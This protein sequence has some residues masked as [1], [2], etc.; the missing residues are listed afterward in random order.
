MAGSFVGGRRVPPPPRLRW[1][2]LT[3]GIA[4]GVGG[5]VVEACGFVLVSGRPAV[6]HV[7]VA[8]A[9]ALTV[10]GVVATGLAAIWMIRARMVETAQIGLAPEV[11]RY[12]SLAGAEQAYLREAES[13]D[14]AV[15]GT[16][17]LRL[18]WF[19]RRLGK[20][21]QARRTF[22]AAARSPVAGIAE[23]ARQELGDLPRPGR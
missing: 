15:A 23:Q 19:Y 10:T 13:T 2:T 18:G 1:R 9:A 20:L 21:N 5:I 7:V 4:A 12:G 22:A 11:A 8:V 3:L 16:A 17:L 6:W 14:P